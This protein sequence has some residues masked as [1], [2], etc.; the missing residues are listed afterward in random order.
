MRASMV[1]VTG[2]CAVGGVAGCGGG[3]RLTDASP[4]MDASTPDGPA[5]A[6]PDAAPS[7]CGYTEKADTSNDLTAEPT[8]LTVGLTPQTLCGTINPGHFNIDTRTVDADAY[9]VTSE[10]PGNLVVRFSGSPGGSAMVG[11]SVFVFTTEEIPTLLFGGSTNP[12]IPDHGVFLLALP[13]GTY[14]IVVSAQN[15]QDLTASF[16]YKVQLAPDGPTRC[17]AVTATATYTEAAD[18]AGA[19]NDVIAVD[20]DV[21]PPFQLTTSMADAPELT[22]LTVDGSTPIRITGSSANED[23]EDDYLDRDVYLVRT[24]AT[25][26]E[27]TLRLGWAD[28]Q[29]NLD[30]IVFPAE[31]TAQLGG[32][33]LLE[34]NEEYNVFAV[35]P[36]SSYWIWVGSHDGSTGLPAGYD[37][38]ICGASFGP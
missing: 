26:S 3:D 29:T 16:P 23:A 8:G 2:L 27:L 15:S 24:A 19:D 21:D 12:T 38:T 32:S 18:G 1:F 36:S 17:P 14:D 20:F 35:Q 10:G 25:T 5:S 22:G 4:A 34:G 31:Q 30:Y 11:F 7:P 6:A 28:A 33:F 9:R 13:A 37:L